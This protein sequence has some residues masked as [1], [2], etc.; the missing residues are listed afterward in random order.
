MTT[1]RQLWVAHS[2]RV[3]VAVFHRVELLLLTEINWQLQ[4]RESPRRR[5]TAQHSER[6]R[7]PNDLAPRHPCSRKSARSASSGADLPRP[8]TTALVRQHLAS[9]RRSDDIP[10]LQEIIEDLRRAVARLAQSR[11]QP[12]INGSGIII[13][14]N[15]GRA[16]LSP[17]A[18]RA[19]TEIG[20][21]YNNVEYRPQLWHSRLARRLPR[22]CARSPLWN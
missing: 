7:F 15:F 2:L 5:D 20:S 8:L 3:L 13:H 21:F 6:V 14:T 11:L 1:S 12:L 16:P 10:P 9:L 19:L 22:A 17:S 4:R 18:I